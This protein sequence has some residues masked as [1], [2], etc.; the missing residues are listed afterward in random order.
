MAARGITSTPLP[1]P[2]PGY[3]VNRYQVGVDGRLFALFSTFDRTAAVR[4]PRAARESDPST[5]LEPIPP[6]AKALLAVAV[7][8]GWRPLVSFP[9]EVYAYAFDV[10]PDD[11]CVV[12]R[13]DCREGE[14]NASVFSH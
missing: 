14:A 6:D 2:P 10:A 3:H 9:L 11:S 7:G 1:R 4:R 5:T 8:A 13:R 12:A